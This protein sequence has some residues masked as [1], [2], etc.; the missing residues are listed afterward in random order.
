MTTYAG[1]SAQY[2]P[3]RDVPNKEPPVSKFVVE[4]L[5]RVHRL[6]MRKI[7]P[8]VDCHVV[9]PDFLTNTT[10]KKNAENARKAKIASQNLYMFHRISKVENEESQY[11]KETRTHV[12]RIEHKALYL[13]KLKVQDRQHKNY[14]IQRE[15]EYILKRI[16]QAQPEYTK[17]KMDEWYNYHKLFK[18]GRRTDP[19]A[20]HIMH[21]MGNLLPPK[22]APLN[23][24]TGSFDL[25]SSVLTGNGS[26]YSPKHMVMDGFA[27]PSVLGERQSLV[28]RILSAPDA[29][30]MP[31]HMGNMGMGR[32]MQSQSAGG[33]GLGGGLEG[34]LM[35]QSLTEGGGGEGYQG[36]YQ[37]NHSHSNQ[38][39]SHSVHSLPQTGQ[40]GQ[41]GQGQG[42]MGQ[43]QGQ[44]QTL[45]PQT[46]QSARSQGQSGRGNGPSLSQSS[47]TPF[48][49]NRTPSPLSDKMTHSK[50][51]SKG[52]MAAELEQALEDLSADD[53]AL[54]KHSLLAATEDL[55][56]L[57]SRPFAL[58]FES[59]NCLVQVYTSKSYDESLQL[60]VG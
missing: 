3:G 55:L 39:M 48:S 50:K 13:K 20:G 11:K 26:V 31:G 9:V 40:M 19:T 16:E 56:L 59:K 47:H 51:S 33:V 49:N 17:K 60:K 57:I 28:N 8:L 29:G 46:N 43:M 54:T 15:N 14:K 25:A 2:V 35:Q 41:M 7:E 1:K 5:Y 58:P 21:G 10:W 32:G 45:M 12:K 42:Q 4:K 24:V 22:L 34:S 53:D 18:L 36:T 6:R 23:S 30:R 44:G 27:D 52:E 37:G 38:Q